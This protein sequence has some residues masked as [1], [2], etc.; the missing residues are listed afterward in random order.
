MCDIS[1]VNAPSRLWQSLERFFEGDQSTATGH[2][3]TSARR[4]LLFFSHI[5]KAKINTATTVQLPRSL[6]RTFGIHRPFSPNKKWPLSPFAPAI[7]PPPP[8]SSCAPVHLHKRLMRCP[9]GCT[10]DSITVSKEAAA[11][12][13]HGTTLATK[14]N[15]HLF[16]GGVCGSDCVCVC[17]G[18]D[19]L[20]GEEK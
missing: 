14:L 18:T 12:R 19:S 8:P 17:V 7:R 1:T 6:M 15:Y 2:G 5:Y 9:L 16:L 13:A 3:E 4:L 10:E 11:T 20:S